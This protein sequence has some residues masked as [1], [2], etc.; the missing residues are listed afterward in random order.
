MAIF[1][2]ADPI[3]SAW[4]NVWEVPSEAANLKT[5]TKL[6]KWIDKNP[7]LGRGVYDALSAISNIFADT[8][9]LESKYG[10][11]L[12]RKKPVSWRELEARLT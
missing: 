10:I 6:Q 2:A 1:G 11:V 9:K 7:D 12:K 8:A 5:D 4:G 3:F